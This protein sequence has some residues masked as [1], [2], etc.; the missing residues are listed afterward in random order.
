M[1]RWQ[2]DEDA[3]TIVFR[4]SSSVHAIRSLGSASGWI[5]GAI[6][7]GGLADG[8]VLLGRLIVPIGELTSG[9]PLFDREMRRRVDT[10]NYPNIVADITTVVAVK[11]GKA[12]ITGTVMFLGEAVNVEGDIAVE[13]GPHITGIGEFDIRWWGL[14]TPRMLMFKVDPIVTVE[15]DLP[16]TN[17][18]TA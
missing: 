9:N 16:L 18:T 7:D 1:Q 4:A 3:S 12:T 5:E 13:R 17:V 15:I 14:E 8:D 6:D 2:I 10:S 11:A